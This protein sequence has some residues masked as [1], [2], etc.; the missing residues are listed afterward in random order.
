M[1]C[2]RAIVSGTVQGVAFRYSTERAANQIDPTT[3]STNS[4]IWAGRLS[5]SAGAN[6]LSIDSINP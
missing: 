6:R 5:F 3:T 1:P 2:V 4:R